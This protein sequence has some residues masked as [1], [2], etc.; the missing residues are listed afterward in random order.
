M[1]EIPAVCDKV[2]VTYRL[3]QQHFPL[4][5]IDITKKSEQIYSIWQQSFFVCHWML[6]L[7]YF[8]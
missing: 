5:S 4:F 3:S 1:F 7:L 8:H 6:Q 2:H